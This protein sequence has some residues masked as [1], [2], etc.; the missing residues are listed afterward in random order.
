MNNTPG[1]NQRRSG[2]T[3]VEVMVAGLL[4]LVFL[5]GALQVLVQTMRSTDLVRRRTEA[6]NLAWSRL[7]R[8]KHMDFDELNDLVEDDPGSI[9]NSAGLPDLDGDYLRRTLITPLSGAM[10]AVQIRVE[11]APR[12]PRTGE[13]AETPQAVESVLTNIQRIFLEDT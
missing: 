4:M 10:E 13:F 6:T 1:P 3:L 11:V 5:G 7:E 12:N 9:V 2:F 8:A